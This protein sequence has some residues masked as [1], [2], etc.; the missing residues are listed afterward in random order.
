MKRRGID[1]YIVPNVFDFQTPAP[2]IDD[3]NR[4]F[5]RQ[6]GLADDEFLILSPVRI[7]PR[8]GLELG[9][10]ILAR[11]PDL[12]C[13]YLLSHSE[14]L[15]QDYLAKI[16]GQ[17]DAAGVKLL[18]LGERLGNRRDIQ[19]AGKT[20]LLW[21]VYPHADFIFYPSLYEGFGNALL[22]AIYFRK[23]VLINRYP[24]YNADIKP[25]DFDFVEIDGQINDE[26]VE[27]IGELL[28]QPNQCRAVG[29]HNYCLAQGHFSYE[30]LQTKLDELFR[31]VCP[32][33]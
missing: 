25:L 28:G 29:N 32:Q 1:S 9:V 33:K 6:V 18:F 11:M 13:R 15:D 12:P 20:Y 3:F 16:R 5:R 2:G 10:E 22:E 31:R 4:D 23:P 26:A 8:K 19:P 30:A 7:I 27:Q 14:D 24:V 17:A 21:D